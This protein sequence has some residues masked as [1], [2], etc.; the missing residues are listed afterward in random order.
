MKIAT[1]AI[2]SLLSLAA[3]PQVS[4]AGNAAV[5]FSPT[6]NPNGVWRYGWENS[7]GG[8]FSTFTKAT[9]FSGVNAWY[10]NEP[11]IG[12]L[13]GYPIIWR[14][15]AASEILTAHPGQ[16]GEYAILRWT[17]PVTGYADISALFMQN[18]NNPTTTDVHVLL[19]GASLFDGTVAGTIHSPP[20]SGSQIF[21][22]AGNSIDFAVGYGSNHSID[23]DTTDMKI[24][25]AVT[26]VPEASA[27]YLFS[28]GLVMLA[29]RQ[30]SISQVRLRKIAA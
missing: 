12:I 11:P 3:W 19:N 14:S 2:A 1:L 6:L 22:N 16:A 21:V 29:F 9:T 7:L 30:R 5:D 13:P 27:A 25:V 26:P 15:I 18:A 28:F 10:G 4:E 23:Y 20:Y 24:S 8:T 17:S